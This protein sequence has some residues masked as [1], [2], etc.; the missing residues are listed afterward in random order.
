MR[1]SPKQSPKLPSK[2]SSTILG[3]VTLNF[4]FKPNAKDDFVPAGGYF[5]VQGGFL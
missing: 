5:N 2:I 4:P 1:E 3:G